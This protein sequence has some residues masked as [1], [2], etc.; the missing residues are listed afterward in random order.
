MKPGGLFGCF[1]RRQDARGEEMHRAPSVVNQPG[2]TVVG[3]PCYHCAKFTYDVQKE[4]WH[5]EHTTVRI[6]A[7]TFSQGG[8]RVCFR[9]DELGVGGD[10]VTSVVKIFK[11]QILV[12]AC[13]CV[14]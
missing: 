13:V 2:S 9:A 4:N 5:R 6:A 1:R 11:P 10:R 14:C 8:M 7:D 3:M 12:R